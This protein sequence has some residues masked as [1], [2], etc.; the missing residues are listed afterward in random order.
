[1]PV[2]SCQR[3]GNGKKGRVIRLCLV[4]LL[5]VV[6]LGMLLERNLEGVILDMAHARAE[7][8]AVEYMHQA[9]RDVM[10]DSVAYEDMITVRTDQAGKITM[11]AANAVRDGTDGAHTAGGNV[12]TPCIVRTI[13]RPFPAVF[14]FYSSLICS[15]PWLSRVRT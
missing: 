15:M 10:G 1:M 2:K 7:A 5:T 13:H 3:K 6:A 4:I 8:M 14:F 12:F 9:V 11:L